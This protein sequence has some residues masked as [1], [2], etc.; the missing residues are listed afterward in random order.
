M[1]ILVLTAFT[2]SFWGFMFGT[3]LESEKNAI[4]LNILFLILFTFGGGLYVNT[5]EG[6][7]LFVALISALS[8]MRYSSELLLRQI[9]KEKSGAFFMLESLG[10]T[11][12]N[13]ACVQR[14]LLFSFTCFIV[15]WISLVLR[16]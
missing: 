1:M 3:F 6:M 15:G 8:P 4:S 12:G 10:F 16:T 13:T 9:L 14:L 11:W 7:N 2:G 5:G